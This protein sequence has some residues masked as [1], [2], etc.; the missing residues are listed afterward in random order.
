MKFRIVSHACIYVEFNSIRLLVDPW[1]YGSCYWRSWWNYP[2]PDDEF[3]KD[4]KPT[5]IY[6]THLHWDHYHG[7]SLRHYE[8]HNPTIVLPK[9]CTRR[10]VT[11]LK[12]YFKFRNIIEIG[13]GQ[14]LNLQS[15]FKITSYQFNPMFVDSCLAI[16]A[17][18][19]SILDLNDCKVFGLSL[20]Q[21]IN[22]H[23]RFDFVLRNHSSASPIPQCIK[24][25]KLAETNR[26]AID[27][28]EEFLESCTSTQARYAIPF[29]SSA[30]MLRE[31]TKKYNSNY[32]NPAYIK[33]IYDKCNSTSQLCVIMPAGSSWSQDN[34]FN[35]NVNNYSKIEEHIELAIIKHSNALE[36]QKR[37]EQSAMLEKEA[38]KS[39]FES[40][41]LSTSWPMSV[42]FRFAYEVNEMPTNLKYLCIVDGQ[43]M[44]TDIVDLDNGEESSNY[45]LSFVIR[46]P[47]LVFNDCNKKKLHNTF[48]PSKILQIE[49][50]DSKGF[51]NSCYLFSLLDLYENDGLPI[52]K[53]LFT[54]RQFINRLMRWRE[55]IDALIYFWKIKILKLPL[56]EL[57]RK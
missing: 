53:S 26:K 18:K 2:E 43:R 40:F 1:V 41:L 23:P 42:D 57:Y 9:A 33:S 8:K 15:D 56:K 4:I 10:M 54:P 30:I 37:K 48:T 35:L 45:Q 36:D 47:T 11:D 31:D 55:I 51:R 49:L 24:G 3:T 21:I 34:G 39:Y 14:S 50:F 32:V 38:F 29:A 13:H 27:Y 6:I 52:L 12:K 20:S 16:E 19:H 25:A 17:G 28:A 46:C 7:P 5:H 44:Q 22:N